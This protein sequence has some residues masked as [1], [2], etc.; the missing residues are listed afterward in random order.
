MNKANLKRRKQTWFARY[1]V[2]KNLQAA[3]GRT[4]VV[5]SLR[6]RDLQEARRLLPIALHRIALEVEAA[7]AS[8]G[9][10]AP[11]RAPAQGYAEL[12]EAHRRMYRA[13]DKSAPSVLLQALDH[14]TESAPDYWADTDAMEPEELAERAA[15]PADLAEALAW[16]ENPDRRTLGEWLVVYLDH[17]QEDGRKERT[18]ATMRRYLEPLVAHFGSR[19]DPSRVTRPA[20]DAYVREVVDKRTGHDGER[21]AFKT[22]WHEVTHAVGFFGWLADAGIITAN[23]FAKLTK[24][25]TG[26]R[27]GDSKRLPFSDAELQALFTLPQ[28][29][30]RFTAVAL[31]GLFSGLRLE[32][33]AQLRTEDCE[34]GA[35]LV[36]EG[37]TASAR[38]AVPV[39]PLI[40]PLVETLRASS[41]SG[42]LFD[43]LE[44]SGLDM[45]RSAAL[46]KAL[47]RWFGT[48]LPGTDAVFHSLRHNHATALERSG[49]PEST[50][51]LLL[52]HKRQGVTLGTY[53]HGLEL[54]QLRKVVSAVT[55]GPEVDRLAAQLAAAHPGN[56][57]SAKQADYGPLRAAVAGGKHTAP[58]IPA[59]KPGSTPGKTRRK[60]NARA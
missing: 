23:P 17:K 6:T 1:F 36:R 55:Y 16:A 34:G 28:P 43:G 26:S 39:H 35:L 40:R 42:Y 33:L 8:G 10:S 49:T 37:K 27:D 7:A 11:V 2:P 57:G 44:A 45:K 54:E 4:E 48:A 59:R 12:L 46:S 50:I 31:V 58:S 14:A 21:L 29:H 25:L 47:G 60:P 19:L 53:A 15:V 38:R 5:Q 41:R 20:A 24:R 30:P 13:G 3:Y 52:G 51:K 22:R 18:V 56:R 32:E 9:C